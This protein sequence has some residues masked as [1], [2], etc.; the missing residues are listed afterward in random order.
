MTYRRIGAALIAFGGAL[1]GVAVVEWSRPVAK[2][3]VEVFT[4]GLESLALVENETVV[5]SVTI[6]NRTR[7][8]L[9]LINETGFG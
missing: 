8:S 4:D 3:H 5:R 7:H 1:L 2:V 9:R 6:T